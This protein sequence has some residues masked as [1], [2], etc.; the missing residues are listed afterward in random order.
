MPTNE[1]QKPNREALGYV[2]WTTTKLTS[3]KT[4][5]GK[6]YLSMVLNQRQRETAVPD[7]EPYQAK[8]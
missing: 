4:G 1:E 6:G 5:G 3:H 7:W 2:P 8:T